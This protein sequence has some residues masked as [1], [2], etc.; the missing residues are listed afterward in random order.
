METTIIAI[1]GA[2]F[3]GALG[4]AATTVISRRQTVGLAR[5]ASLVL[6][7][8]D[9][10]KREMLRSAELEARKLRKEILSETE[11]RQLFL[12]ELE[13]TLQSRELNLDKKTSDS[14]KSRLDWEH[15]N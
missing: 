5:K 3:G 10:Q 14:E 7:K 8:A 9:E 13:K 15:R 1:F 6:D 12:R 2:I 11:E 4:V